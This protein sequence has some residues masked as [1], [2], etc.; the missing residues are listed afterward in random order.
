MIEERGRKK[1]LEQGITKARRD[2]LLK[3]LRGR[4]R[5]VPK[6]AVARIEAADIAQ[7]DRWLDQI[8]TAPTLAEA[9]ADR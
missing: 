6:A 9:L 2:I 5:A 3:L 4:F 7:L 1:G 8:L